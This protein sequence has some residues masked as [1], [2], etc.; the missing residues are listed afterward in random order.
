MVLVLKHKI[1]AAF[2][3]GLLV[4]VLAAAPA[5]AEED[6]LFG[7]PA[8]KRYLLNK[9]LDPKNTHNPEDGQAA[10][11]NG[12]AAAG[13]GQ[14]AAE[15]GHVAGGNGK[16][17]G[18]NGQVAAGEA[19]EDEDDRPGPYPKRYLLNKLFDGSK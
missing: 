8:P 5:R 11:G 15:N 19:S 6:T 7:Q 14:A 10:A 16:P 13:N 9:M 18:G 2:A 17:A 1:S 4:A 12:Q 3:G